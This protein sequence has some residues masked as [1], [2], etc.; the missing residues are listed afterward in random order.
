VVVKKDGQGRR[1]DDRR[2]EGRRESRFGR[3]PQLL[4]DGRYYSWIG[5]LASCYDAPMGPEFA[6]KF[7][8]PFLGTVHRV[9]LYIPNLAAALFLL[10]AGL[11]IARALRTLT[12]GLLA[13]TRL[14]EHTSKIGVNEVL[15]RMGLGKSPSYG[16]AFLIYWFMLFVFIVAAA[17][18]VNMTALSDLLERFLLFLPNLLAS[19]L[20]LFGGLLFA[21]F[22]SEVVAAASAAN[23]IRGGAGLSRAIY[24]SVVVSASITALE[25][26][27]LQLTFITAAIQI[28]LASAGLAFGLAF[29]LGGK[30]LAAEF[31][32]NWLK[33]ASA[34]SAEPR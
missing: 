13:K 3:R 33:G 18:A 28:I 22:L 16:I 27:G 6:D 26:L 23:N 10:I 31:L 9:A 32:R 2:L 17:N 1:E 30:D 4:L 24:V 5:G 8:N 14:D 15:A 20:I 29:G 34:S 11:F 7:T 19:V 12:E 21:R 25:Q